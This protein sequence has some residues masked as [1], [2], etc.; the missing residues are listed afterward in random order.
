MPNAIRKTSQQRWKQAE[1]E[2]QAA[3]QTKE[4]KENAKEIRKAVDADIRQRPDVAADLLIG[5]GEMQGQKLKQRWPLRAEDLTDLQKSLLPRHYYS[6]DGLP[7]DGVANML[8]F[9]SGD[10]YG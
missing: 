5:G 10:A 1:K 9:Q 6:K 7:V 2:E 3:T 8:G 4:W